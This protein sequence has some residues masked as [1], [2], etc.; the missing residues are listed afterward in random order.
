M[1]V[2][3]QYHAYTDPYAPNRE[4]MK[5]SFIDELEGYGLNV[6]NLTRQRVIEFSWLPVCT[7]GYAITRRGAE[8]LLYN[9]GVKVE[10][11]SQPVDIE[12]INLAQNGIARSYTVVPP[13]FTPFEYKGRK[14]S[15]TRPDGDIEGELAKTVDWEGDGQSDNLRKSVRVALRERM[16]RFLNAT[17]DPTT[18]R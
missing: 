14:N 3:P 18:A 13:L 12:M 17:E 10:G 9:V 5:A 15:N 2:Y 16:T 11:F 4:E 1:E 7:V 6:T 8:K